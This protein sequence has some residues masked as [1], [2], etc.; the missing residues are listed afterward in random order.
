MGTSSSVP[1]LIGKLE[2][3]GSAVVD[4]NPD[5]VKRVVAVLKVGVLSRAAQI[6]GG[7]LTFRNNNRRKIGARDE[8]IAKGVQSATKVYGTG[9][10][11]W[12]E[13]GVDPHDI[14]PG[15]KRGASRGLLGANLRGAA[16]PVLPASSLFSKGNW[17]ASTRGAG[18]VLRF[19]DGTFSRYARNAGVL[20]GNRSWSGGVDAAERVQG[21]VHMQ[22]VLSAGRR[23]GF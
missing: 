12:V 13:D 16:G 19:S 23:A 14:V 15:A 2:R 4:T 17:A 9:P 1:Q 18:V 21:Q 5:N 6:A 11:R 10:M 22:G 3:F 20:K 7:D 8:V